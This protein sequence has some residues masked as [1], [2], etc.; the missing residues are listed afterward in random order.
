MFV[1][2][3][4]SVKYIGHL[5]PVSI[6]RIFVG[7]FYFN[8]ALRLLGSNFLTQAYLAEDIRSHFAFGTEPMW[9][10]NFL[11][12]M[13]IPNWQVFAYSIVGIQFFIGISYIIGYLVRPAALMG[14]L[15]TWN[16]LWATAT[17]V[18]Q[19]Q[20]SVLLILNITLGWIGAG[21]CLGFDYFFYKR[22]RGIW[23]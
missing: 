23:W 1:A 14:I 4:E 3:F 13:V 17:D 21:R 10:R 20:L 18:N 6:L 16:L 15:L 22:R 2:F 19:W 7:Y 8:E 5:F 9:Y 11:E 12:W